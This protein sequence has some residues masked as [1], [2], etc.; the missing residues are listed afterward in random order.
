M[1]A[2]PRYL[3]GRGE[4]L[5]YAIDPLSSGTKTKPV[6]S[7][8][9]SLARLQPQITRTV[10]QLNALPEAACPRDEAVA[11]VTLHPQS[12]SKSAQPVALLRNLGLRSIGSRPTSLVPKK[13]RSGKI[14][15]EMPTNELFVAGTRTTLSDWI[16]ALPSL[17]PSLQ[18]EF[19]RLEAVRAPLK[20]DRIKNIELAKKVDGGLAMELV[21]HAKKETDSDLLEGFMEYCRALDV[22]AFQNKAIWVGGL[23]YIPAVVPEQ[24]LAPLSLFSYLR[25]A[26]PTAELRQ[27]P[28]LE[29]SQRHE[30]GLRAPLPTTIDF[31]APVQVAVFDGG[32][33][34][35][36]CLAPWAQ[37][38]TG[39]PLRQLPR[40]ADHGQAVTSALV[41]G[42]LDSDGAPQAAPIT[43]DMHQ[44]ID[45]DMSDSP[46]DLYDVLGQVKS[47]LD[48]SD[49]SFVNLSVGPECPVDDE[50]IHP[51]TAALDEL[52]SSGDM[53]IT[54]AVGNTGRSSDLFE[55]RIQVP[56]DA[57]NTM[58]I[59]ACD[60]QRADWHRAPY[61]SLGPGRSPGVVKP[62]LLAFGGSGRE[63]FFYVDPDG[64]SLR[65]T[66]GTSFASPTALR[67]GV[68]L[69]HSLGDGIDPLTLRALLINSTQVS[70]IERT[71]IGWGA[72]PSQVR[73]VILCSDG[74]VRVIYRG[75]IRPGGWIR[76]PIPIPTSGMVG[77]VE[78]GATFV[79]ACHTD[80]ADPS[81]YSRSGLD[82]IFRPHDQKLNENNL[83]S[84][85]SFFS[86]TFQEERDLRKLALKW[87]TVRH[88]SHRFQHKTLHNPVFEVHHNA[89][90]SGQPTRNGTELP[91][92]LVISVSAP[93]VP[94]LYDKVLQL[95]PALVP[96]RPTVDVPVEIR[97]QL[98]I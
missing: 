27:L 75:K 83:P 90:E 25:M 64:D 57:L 47:T 5:T 9:E 79:Y 46:F 77:M 19:T 63:P 82:I 3:L 69:K 16:N 41:F 45:T 39:N 6:Y 92:A 74:E 29:R 17:R 91:Y 51:W 88:Q 36:S 80:P 42:S 85:K 21:L 76:M 62:D 81:N 22:N 86:R 97:T 58:A 2:E 13:I 52:T 87:D 35:D 30:T 61:S 54:C 89:R 78:V 38:A 67:F 14:P 68:M 33:P 65:E 20:S 60:S 15:S 37:Q 72:L 44:V 11:L 93:R 71:E 55:R 34:K 96:L 56:S 10:Q 24:A 59:G 66:A 70:T 50:E 73:D 28:D 43:I 32:L 95:Y 53:L 23:I 8:E 31:S 1:T 48:E 4:L 98:D 18:D 49:Y 84:T 40:A 12:I 94:D 26:R 7:W